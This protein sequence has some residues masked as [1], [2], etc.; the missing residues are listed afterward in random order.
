[1]MAGMDDL[2]R[3]CQEFDQAEL[4]ADVDRVETLLT[5]DFLSI[6]E[7]GFVLDKS[8]WV[9]RHADFTYLSVESL[10]LDVRRY[11]RCAIIRDI[12][13]SRATWQGRAMTLKTR[14]SQVWVEQSEGW[15]LAAIQFSSLAEE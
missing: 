8:Q 6:G 15:K 11:D 9:A 7:R 2:L 3:S 4:Q 12:H 14:R 13:H 10:D 5:D 1:M